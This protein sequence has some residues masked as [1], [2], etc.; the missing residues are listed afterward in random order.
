MVIE[1]VIDIRAVVAE[2]QGNA[3]VESRA[4]VYCRENGARGERYDA[5]FPKNVFFTCRL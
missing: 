1:T 2:R 3:A 4:L 5:I